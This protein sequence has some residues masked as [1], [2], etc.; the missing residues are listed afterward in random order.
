VIQ[1]WLQIALVA[2][3][4]ALVGTI[5]GSL[6]SRPRRAKPAPGEAEAAA[7]ALARPTVPESPPLRNFRAI[8]EKRGIGGKELDSQIEDFARQYADLQERLREI[9]PADPALA[10]L[11]DEARRALDGGNFGH[12]LESLN[13][14]GERDAATGRDLVEKAG[15]HLLT[16]ATAR[17]AAGDLHLAQMDYG[18]AL[19]TYGEALA[20]LPEGAETLRAECLN[21]HGTAAYHLGEHETATESFAEAL[22]ILERTLGADHPDL[23][24]ALNNLALLYYSQGDYEA[25]EPLYE[26][27]LAIDEKVLGAEHPGVATDLN[28]L[29]LLYKKQGNFEAAEPLLR[30]ALAIKEKVFDPGHASLVMGLKN[31][32]SLLRV[33]DRVEEAETLES[34]AATLPQRRTEA[35]E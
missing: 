8:L 21:K 17:A 22:R 15:K 7:P 1:E 32:A 18:D 33:L 2:G 9:A 14:L 26:R 27:A 34:R 24:T 30:R 23:A 29:A 31:Y 20:V 4:A 10:A 6:I 12:A 11:A 3:C 5:V 16:A 13:Q 28:N 25:A 35:A 19:R